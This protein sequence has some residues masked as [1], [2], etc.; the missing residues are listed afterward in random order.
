MPVSGCFSVFQNP[1]IALQTKVLCE[2][3]DTPVNMGKHILHN[4]GSEGWGFK[5]L[6]MHHFFFL[7]TKN[8]IL[9]GQPY[10]PP[11][12][13]SGMMAPKP[14]AL[15]RRNPASTRARYHKARNESGRS[16]CSGCG[17]TWSFIPA[18]K[19]WRPAC[20]QSNNT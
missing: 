15:F 9:V 8:Q 5:S 17:D 19:I 14:P 6:R 11:E 1:G 20:C 4:F 18:D 10:P 16:T 3:F 13:G 2:Q 12:L 7:P